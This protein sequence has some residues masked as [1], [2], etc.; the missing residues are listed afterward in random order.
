MSN[1]DEDATAAAR[2]AMEAHLR[3]LGVSPSLARRFSYVV[4]REP[5]GSCSVEVFQRKQ[6]AGLGQGRVATVDLGPDGPEL[7]DHGIL[8]SAPPSPED[9]LRAVRASVADV[10]S[11]IRSVGET[12]W[13]LRSL[14][15]H[16]AKTVDAAVGANRPTEEV[17]QALVDCAEVFLRLCPAGRELDRD[18]HERRAQP[19][20]GMF[21]LAS[22]LVAGAGHLV[23]AIATCPWDPTTSPYLKDDDDECTPGDARVAYAFKCLVAGDERAARSH[24]AS[25]PGARPLM[26]SR[27]QLLQAVV[28]GDRAG[29]LP[30]LHD[31]TRDFSTAAS[32]PGQLA[33]LTDVIDVITLGITRVAIS[34]QLIDLTELARLNARSLPWRL[35]GG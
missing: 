11:E 10:L 4:S 12:P 13:R 23:T 19:N 27:A 18:P 16:S 1:T 5:G 7:R 31:V 34:R 32:R 35:I 3:T 26:R 6:L 8:P 28:S 2:N 29:V 17:H 22:A 25:V 14:C 20:H 30:R 24:L 21:C 15:R 9:I 33:E